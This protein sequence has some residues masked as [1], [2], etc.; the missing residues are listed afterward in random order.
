[1]ATME[2][3]DVAVIDNP[4]EML[5]CIK[6]RQS[7]EDV[8]GKFLGGQCLHHPPFTVAPPFDPAE[9]IK[10]GSFYEVDHSKL[11]HKSPDQLNKIRVV[12][13]NEKTRM[14]VS[15]RFPSINYLR[16]YFNEI[17]AINYKKDMKMKK[18]QLPAFDEKY[19]IG[20]EVAAEAL[21]RRISSQ[22]IADKSNSWSFWMVKHPSVSPRKVSYPP[23]S[24]NVNNIVGARK[25]S[26]M[27]DLNETGMVKWGQRRQA[28]FL[29]KHVEDKRE[30]VTASKDL[31]KDEEEKDGDASDDDTEEEEEVDVKLAVN[32][33]GEAKRKLR[34]RKCQGGS[35]SSNLSPKKKRCKIGKKN[36]IVVYRQKKNKLIKNSIDRWSAERYKLAEENMLKV[37]KEQDAVF[38]RPILRPELRAEARKL[39]GDTGL[40]DHLLK[41]MSGKV[42]P[43][44]EERFR[45]RHNADGAMEYWLEKADLVDIRKEAGVQDPYW[46]P[47]PGWKPGDNPSQDPVC[48]RDIREL[49]EEI[50]KIKGEMKAMVSKKQGEELAMVAAPNYSPT[51]QD[52]EHDNLLIPLKEMYIDLVNKK[53]KMEEQLKEISE[54][55]YGMEEEMEKLKTRVEKSKRTESTERPAFLMGST[56][57]ITPAG[58]GRKG[59]GVMRQEKDATALG[60]LA[61]EQCKSSSGGF[62]APGTESPAPS[63]DRAAKIERL[64]SGFTLCKPQGSFLWPDMT[65]LTPHSQVV[66][67]LEDLIT[68]HTPPSVSSTSPKQS[69]YLFA[70]PSQTHI[71]HR[72]SPVRPL[73]ERRP[74]TIPQ[75]TASTTP[76]TCPLLDQMTHFRYENSSI[77]TSTTTT[78]T[79][80][81]NLNEP[82][83][84]NQT[85]DYGLF[86]GSQSHAQ[87]FPYP[88]TYQRRHHQN[89]AMPSL[90]PTEKGTMS[91]WEEGDRRKGM[92]R[93]CERC[94]QQRGCS[95]A[96]S[97]ASSSLPMGMGAWLALATSKASVEHK[98]KRG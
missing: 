17:E 1:M 88:V 79:P 2:L 97:I 98:S 64:K 54:S 51:S 25:V 57:S 85:D 44:G 89:I 16:C 33:S 66:V 35:G 11:P 74:V 59:K 91:R 47:P 34:K 68:V 93:Y 46:T 56:E 52:M 4:S 84:T 31:I 26:L 15:L 12:M 22:E 62:I 14:R 6:R 18:Q 83:N 36:Q 49:R 38:R 21:Y 43:G 30:I 82:L 45:R 5:G 90:G 10:V 39:I 42:A 50:A 86:C 8:G 72:T 92:I 13:V 9:H 60:E 95:S 58:T 67:Q 29:A 69:R 78:K 32:K 73:A 20:S 75:S 71:P 87:A 63:E 76:I 81:V 28:R 37:M 23:T 65:T 96:S 61:Q 7:S 70:P 3:V 94:E 24:T 77:S 40:L 27:S 19:I 80:L 48:A 53:V 41:H 55:L